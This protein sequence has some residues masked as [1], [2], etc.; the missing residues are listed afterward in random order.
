MQLAF[1][2]ARYVVA[3]VIVIGC[4][5]AAPSAGA[6]GSHDD[7]LPTR[8]E[9]L[10]E[11]LALPHCAG[12]SIVEWKPTSEFAADT[13]PSPQALEVIDDT[14]RRALERYPEFLRERG[15]AALRDKPAR[16]PR[17]SLLPGNVLVDGL[18]S[19]NLNDVS[20]RFSGV[21][22]RCCYWG[23]YVETLHHLFVRNDPLVHDLRSGSAQT[24]PR[25][26]RTLLHELAHVLNAQLGVWEAMGEHDRDLDER[27]A[28]EWV[29]WLGIRFPTESSSDDYALHAH[30]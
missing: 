11:P 21:A 23:L 16:M 30:R 10:P 17:V 4:V 6:R 9:R 20:G 22:Q 15:I 18:D 14:C 12:A 8:A 29:G 13:T 7:A 5:L 1:R 2:L 26:V 19:R 25:F 24:N 28:E 3:F 27:L